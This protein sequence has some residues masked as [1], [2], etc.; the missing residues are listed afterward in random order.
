MDRSGPERRYKVGD[1]DFR[2]IPHVRLWHEE[3]ELHLRGDDADQETRQRLVLVEVGPGI[4]GG[5]QAAGIELG[6]IAEHVGAV[7]EAG[8]EVDAAGVQ[9]EGDGGVGPA[10]DVVGVVRLVGRRILGKGWSEIK[11]RYQKI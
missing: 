1:G 3:V 4:V 8:V 11:A 7:D 9:A 6:V 2:R 5:R 10:G